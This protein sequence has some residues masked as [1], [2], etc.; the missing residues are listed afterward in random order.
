M[1]SIL[2]Q[3]RD[4][5]YRLLQYNP[6]L[7]QETAPPEEIASSENL[8]RICDKKQARMS[9]KWQAFTASKEPFNIS[10]IRIEYVSDLWAHIVDKRRKTFVS[11]LAEKIRQIDNTDVVPKPPPTFHAEI[12]VHTHLGLSPKVKD[13]ISRLPD[14]W[15]AHVDVCKRL[16]EIAVPIIEPA[17]RAV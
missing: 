13:E 17:E 16:A 7:E 4:Y 10:V 1:R 2:F 3:I 9:V 5:L 11:L 15:N 14:L 6:M 8:A 12:L